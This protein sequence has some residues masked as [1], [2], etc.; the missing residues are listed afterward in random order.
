[1]MKTHAGTAPDYSIVV[2]VFNSEK[3][4]RPLCERIAGVMEQRGASFEIL[5]VHDGGTL[6]SWSVAAE[7][8]R[9][10]EHVIAI[11]LM[12][13]Y[14][15]SAATMCG[16]GYARGRFV[17]TIDDDLQSPPEEIGVLI[18]AMDERPELDAIFGAPIE[19]H[20]ALHRRLGSWALNK[21]SAGHI[22]SMGDSDLKLTSFRIL[23]RPIVESLLAVRTPHPA[24]GAMLCSITPR[25]ANVPVRHEARAHG[26]GG[27]SLGKLLGVTID[28]TLSF[29]TLPLRTLATVGVLGILASVVLGGIYLARY[30]VGGVGVPGWTTMV[31]LMIGIAGFNFFA[32]GVVGEYLLRILQTVQGNPQYLVRERVGDVAVADVVGRGPGETLAPQAPEPARTRP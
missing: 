24:P 2:P 5:L 9:G 16:L 17:I 8:A 3:T 19:K 20:H 12:R 18:E 10:G 29:S 22:F 6:G 32:F 15:Q 25:I 11:Q 13:N 27:Y 7:L 23:R 21:L 31:L 30:L 26:R 14:G 4:L 28:K 1:M